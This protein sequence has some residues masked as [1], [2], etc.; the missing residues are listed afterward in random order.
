MLRVRLL[1]VLLFFFVSSCASDNAGI[2]N[3]KHLSQLKDSHSGSYHQ[4]YTAPKY[5]GND[6]NTCLLMEGNGVVA[7]RLSRVLAETEYFIKRHKELEGSVEYL[8]LIYDRDNVKNDNDLEIANLELQT[9]V[10]GFKNEMADELVSVLKKVV[11]DISEER[12]FSIV[13][14]GDNIPK[15]ISSC[16]NIFQ[17]EDY[18][19]SGVNR[20]V[21]L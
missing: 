9:M 16:P 8:K 2:S 10:S 7:V 21:G 13:L 4:I 1:V 6:K 20:E 14:Y 11:I 3:S 17:F 18:I 15:N 5:R 19:I 12:G